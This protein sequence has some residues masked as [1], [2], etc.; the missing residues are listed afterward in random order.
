MQSLFEKEKLERLTK[1]KYQRLEKMLQDIELT[2]NNYN[3]LYKTMQKMRK[4]GLYKI[5]QPFK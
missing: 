1:I 5:N 3:T 4:L 2:D